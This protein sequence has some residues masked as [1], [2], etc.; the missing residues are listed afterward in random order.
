MT[1]DATSDEDYDSVH[2]ATHGQA[3]TTYACGHLAAQP[4]Q[5]WYCDAPLAPQ[6]L[7]RC[8]VRG[9]RC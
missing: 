5:Q 8:L 7:A 6:P 9:L 3:H 4:V 2:C 1:D